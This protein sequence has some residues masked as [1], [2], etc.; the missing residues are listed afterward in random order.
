MSK[1][2]FLNYIIKLRC[3]VGCVGEQSN[4]KWWT[5]NFFASSSLAFLQP[6]FNKTSHLAIYQGVKNEASIVHDE[7][8][9]AGAGVYHLF[10]LPETLEI[11]LLDVVRDN[12]EIVNESLESSVE[13]LKSESMNNKES[14]EGPIFID[15]IDGISNLENWR[16]VASFYNYA[17]ENEV[18]VYPFFARGK[19]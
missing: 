3:C 16:K 12:A 14:K 13:F 5:G 4:N 18:S 11:D 15:K 9:G 1:Q 19:R 2:E 7:Y 10:R 8:I 6:I 17:F